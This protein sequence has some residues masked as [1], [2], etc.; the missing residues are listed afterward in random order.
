MKF[1]VALACLTLISFSVSA[2]TCSRASMS[3]C[4]SE[5]KCLS[6]NKTGGGTPFKF[7]GGRCIMVEPASQGADC[8]VG[9]QSNRRGGKVVPPATGKSIPA[10]SGAVQ[11]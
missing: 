3:S 8:L 4:D 5:E 6:L 9:D 11:R 1:F 2:D 10:D 7:E